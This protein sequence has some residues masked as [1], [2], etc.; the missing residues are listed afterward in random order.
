MVSPVIGVRLF[1]SLFGTSRRCALLPPLLSL[2]VFI[3]PDLDQKGFLRD[4]ISAVVYT[5]AWGDGV[6]GMGS[7]FS[8]PPVSPLLLG[9]SSLIF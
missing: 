2:V 3:M 6:G 5:S 7:V 1:A 9:V 8:F 4:D